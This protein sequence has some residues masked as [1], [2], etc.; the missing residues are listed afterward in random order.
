M[1]IK[2]IQN[3]K[4]GKLVVK[5]NDGKIFVRGND[6][7]KQLGY[8]NPT[9]YIKRYC[10]EK[11]K[12]TV[13]RELGGTSYFITSNDLE[14]LMKN[15]KYPD[16]EEYKKY[17]LKNIS[18]LYKSIKQDRTSENQSKLLS[19]NPEIRP[20]T[21]DYSKNTSIK[22]FEHSEFG[23]IRVVEKNGEPWWV[24]KDVCKVLEMDTTQL[25]KV[26][27]RLEPDE[28]DRNLIT[29]PGGNQETWIINESGL[30]NVILR[31][32]KPQAKPFRKW[33]T[34]EVLPS[35]R[36]T[37]GYIV[38][39]DELSPSELMARALMVAQKTLEEREKRINDLS[40]RNALIEPKAEYYDNV[41]TSE[42]AIQ[43]NVIAKDYGM[44]AI[45]FNKL[46]YSLRIQ[47][48]TSKD[49]WVLYQEYAS[50]GYTVTQTILLK[51]GGS[52]IHT[53]W[54]QKGREFLYKKLKENGYV[55]TS[56]R[57]LLIS[58]T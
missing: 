45:N 51:S 1:D 15:S 7:A 10:S 38:G 11:I 26:V 55:P 42:N 29:T 40:K 41:L 54:T 49:T 14:N 39:Q 44:S 9:N 2:I 28:R 20:D 53:Y 21:F 19:V 50:K 56:E 37:G 43:T 22:V 57:N 35:I 47:Y 30:Y 13:P 16:K 36:K 23:S 17:I 12:F 24:L 8:E 48:K 33:V 5:Y 3:E 58:A 25:K 32:D 27:N 31:S 34:S 46:L 52:V 4:F 6:V 18:E